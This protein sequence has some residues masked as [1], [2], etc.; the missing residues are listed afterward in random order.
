MG[1]M[2]VVWNRG[3][4][5]NRVCGC[6]RAFRECPMWTQVFDQAAGGMAAVDA[7]HMTQLRDQVFN[8][9]NL[10]RLRALR[11]YLQGSQGAPPQP[12]AALAGFAGEVARIYRAA[13]EVTGGRVLIDS[14]HNPLYGY[15]VGSIPDVEMSVVHLIRD[16]RAVMFS[17]QRRKF[18]P[19]RGKDMRTGRPAY[20][21]G[22][23]VLW[24]ALSELLFRPRA[25]RY[26]QI[27]Y[28]DFVTQPRTA[29]QKIV[30]WMGGDPDSLPFSSEHEVTVKPSHSVSGN[31][32]R[33]ELG[34]VTLHLDSQWKT[35]GH[36]ADHAL[37]L[38]VTWP[39]LLRYNYP[40]SLAG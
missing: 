7:G 33:F 30:T 8:P 24:N 35:Q 22:G 4:I 3:L 13:A 16:P 11:Q 18:D 28:E 39:W 23:W 32:S 31:P 17:R 20:V 29:A 10:P 9:A 1:E 38:L 15:L 34:A 5:E 2:S 6:G 25:G 19:G 12:L 40:L 36:P 27:R 26:M 14:S 37:A 21:V